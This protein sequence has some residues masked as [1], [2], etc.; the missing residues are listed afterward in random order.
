[1]L[2]EQA[3]DLAGAVDVDTLCSRYL[4]QAGHRHDVAGQGNHEASASGDL[5]VAHRDGEVA[6]RYICIGL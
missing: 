4:R 3:G 5:D 1:M 2:L 6:R